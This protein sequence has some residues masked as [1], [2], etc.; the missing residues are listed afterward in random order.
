MCPMR[1]ALKRCGVHLSDVIVNHSGG[2]EDK[3]LLLLLLL[4]LSAREKYDPQKH[5][6]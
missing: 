4:L 6:A 2:E 1:A 3:R 5:S